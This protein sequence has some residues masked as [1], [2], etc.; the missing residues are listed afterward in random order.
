MSN[1]I[2]GKKL[3]GE[4][5]STVKQAVSDLNDRG[6]HP[7]LATVIVGN[8]SAS[9]TYVKNKIKSSNEVGIKSFN[10]DLDEKVDEEELIELIRKLNSDEKVDAILVQ[11]PLSKHLCTS[12][13][14]DSI[15]P[16]KDVDGFSL[17]NAGRTFLNRHG[18][19]PCTPMGCL[20]LLRSIKLNMEGKNAII[21]GRSNIVG[22]PMSQLLLNENC[23]VTVAH[24]YTNNLSKVTKEAD[25]IIAATGKQQMIKKDWVKKGAVVI[26][27]GINRVIKDRKTYLVGDVDFKEVSEIASYITPVPG[28]VGP[29]TI[30]CLLVNTVV[31][32]ANRRNIRVYKDLENLLN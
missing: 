26:D 32:A 17:I 12:K 18:V 19:V 2:D 3:A 8:N 21:I 7:G 29:M 22:K 20:L 31:L 9:R 1:I 6:V 16:D 14:I 25:I 27:V 28:G 10:Y 5:R 15:N 13:I 4:I 30:A 24:S 23:T 11:L